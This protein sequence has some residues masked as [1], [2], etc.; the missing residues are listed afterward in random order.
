LGH[1][2]ARADMCVALP[3]LA[4]RFTNI[5]CPGG[6]QWLPDSGNTGPIRYPITFDLR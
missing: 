6:D 1:Y 3:R 4:A 2:I 5:A